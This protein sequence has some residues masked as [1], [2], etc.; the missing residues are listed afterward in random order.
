MTPMSRPLFVKLRHMLL[1]NSVFLPIF[2]FPM[3]GSVPILFPR[4]PALSPLG[5]WKIAIPA[6]CLLFLHTCSLKEPVFDLRSF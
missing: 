2:L 5:L 6:V 3:L 4:S 1:E